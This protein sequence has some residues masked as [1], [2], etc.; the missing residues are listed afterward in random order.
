M[1]ERDFEQAE[2]EAEAEAA[3][4]RKSDGNSSAPTSVQSATDTTL[5]NPFTL[6]RQRNSTGGGFFRG[7]LIKCDYRSGEWVR[8]HGEERTLID[9]DERFIVNPHEMIDTWTKWVDGKVIDR[10]IYRTSDGQ[11]APER[12]ALGDLDERQW[13]YDRSGR[14]RLDPWQ[15]AVFLPM[16]GS[17]GEVV[18]FR[19]TGQ[20]AIAEIGELVGMYGSADRHGRFPIVQP[21]ARSFES[22]H[23]SKIFVPVFRLVGWDYWEPDTPAPQ[24]SPVAVPIA[25]RTQSRPTPR[26]LPKRDEGGDMDDEIPF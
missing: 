3:T 21:D 5:V 4:P 17:D 23:G 19:A 16:K 12:D 26:Q 20:G 15:R 18:A 14:K 24:V 2:A 22:Q 1:Q 11:F 7:D 6:F 10:Q 8:E 25:A 13:P 9:P